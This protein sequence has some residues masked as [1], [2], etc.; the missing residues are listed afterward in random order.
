MQ[1]YEQN[2]EKGK[3]EQHNI[4]EMAHLKHIMYGEKKN[5]I[6]SHL[7]LKRVIFSLIWSITKKKSK[8]KHDLLLS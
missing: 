8:I 2:N 7:K 5:H 4:S 1:S 3:T 6:L